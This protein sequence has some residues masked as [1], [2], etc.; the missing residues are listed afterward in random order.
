MIA[1][2][3]YKYIKNLQHFSYL[4]LFTGSGLYCSVVQELYLFVWLLLIIIYSLLPVTAEA[5]VASATEE[6][7]SGYESEG[8]QSLSPSSP[9]DC[10]P[11][12]PPASPPSGR[13]PR[14]AFTAEQIST[15]EKAFKRN[16]YLGTKDK[17]ELCRKLKLSDKQVTTLDL[18][19]VLE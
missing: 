19:S 3:K 16:A 4:F 9:D 6:E 2:K 7:T 18:E 1:N 5:G 14:T 10:T 11:G 13:R 15:M 12:S 8:G 17:A